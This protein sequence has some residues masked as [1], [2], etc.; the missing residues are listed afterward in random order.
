M[1]HPLFSEINKF[2]TW[3]EAALSEPSRISAEW[4]TGYSDWAAIEDNFKDF[5]RSVP[6]SHWSSNELNR[7]EYIIARDNECERLVED[8]NDDALIALSEY[9]LVHGEQ[10]SKWQFA[11]ALPRIANTEK[12]IELVERFVND[13]EEYVNRRALMA[14]AKVDPQKAE[15]YCEAHW[16]RNLYGDVDEYQRM[17]ILATLKEIASPLLEKYLKL[18]KEDGRPYLVNLALELEHH[19]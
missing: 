14:F 7:M 19:A 8:L 16:T 17:A 15:R 10:D 11:D 18:A 4:E 6:S 2:E 12:A 13:P 3:A 1:T 9:A 5:I